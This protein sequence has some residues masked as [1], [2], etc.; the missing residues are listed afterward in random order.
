MKLLSRPS[1]RNRMEI[2]SH[3]VR[4]VCTKKQTILDP[5]RSL[6]L[7][8]VKVADECNLEANSARPR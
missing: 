8:H 5:D 6:L 1:Q 2:F 7:D 3:E 4:I